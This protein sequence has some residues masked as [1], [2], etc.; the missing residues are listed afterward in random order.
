MDFSN[1]DRSDGFGGRTA[2][3][4]DTAFEQPYGERSLGASTD[5]VVQLDTGSVRVG[6]ADDSEAVHAAAERGTSGPGGAL[7]HQDRIQRAFGRHDVGGVRAHVGGAAAEGAEAMGASAFATG[8]DV[9]FA[10]APDLHTAA[11]EAAHVVQQRGGVQLKG[12]VGATGDA[13]E[14]HADAVADA[15]VAGE[16]AQGLLDQMAPSGGG[17]GAVQRIVQMEKF[18][19]NQ[20]KHHLHVEIN[21]DHYKFGNDKGSRIEIGKNGVYKLDQLIVARNY[22]VDGGHTTLGGQACID[23][24]QNECTTHDAWDEDR[25]YKPSWEQGEAEANPHVEGILAHA[26]ERGLDRAGFNKAFVQART[27]VMTEEALHLD[28]NYYR[29]PGDD[30]NED[31]VVIGDLEAEMEKMSLDQILVG[32]SGFHT[33]DYDVEAL[34]VE[35]KR[36]AKL[37]IK[38]KL[39]DQFPVTRGKYDM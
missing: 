21:Q 34:S 22:L 39:R 28:G 15:V 9:A 26:D 25:G 29:K 4:Q 11:H 5:L 8:N 31:P 14:Q 30:D 33:S 2:P 16:S 10:D 32:W 17:G 13:Y 20:A 3:Q 27:E 24:L 36:Y 1:R 35:F 12:G 7:P 38:E 6:A 18:V 37:A 23:W 19:G